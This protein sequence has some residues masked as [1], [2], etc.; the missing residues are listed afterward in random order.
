MG[1]EKLWDKELKVFNKYNNESTDFGI[2]KVFG[3][4]LLALRF[5]TLPALIVLQIGGVKDAVSN[6]REK[7]IDFYVT[8]KLLISVLIVILL[9]PSNKDNV[10]S[11]I[12]V[13]WV[14]YSLLETLLYIITPIYC[15]QSF[16]K[17]K[18]YKRAFILGV[19]N[20]FEIIFYFAFL[21][22]Y[23][24]AIKISNTCE[25]GPF[26]NLV[27]V[28]HSLIAGLTIGFG[29]YIPSGGVGMYLSIL[30][31]VIFFLFIIVFFNYNFS[32]IKK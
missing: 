11:M 4:I 24:D 5:A 28:Y 8:A 26:S 3:I 25:S 13:I 17:P 22:F 23:F 27:Y 10:W 32:N 9:I 19:L 1:L 6:G 21:Y 31:G 20:Y 7:T 29:D 30:Q 2:V 18:S 16:I 14:F 15:S 12:S